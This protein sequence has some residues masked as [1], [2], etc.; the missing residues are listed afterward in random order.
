MQRNWIGKSVGGEITFDLADGQGSFNVFTTRA[1][2]LFG[3]TYVVLAPEHPLVKQIT[4][5]SQLSAVE[6]YCDEVA[7]TDEIERLSTAKDKTGQYLRA[8]T[9]LTP[10]TDSACRCG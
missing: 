7:K 3:C 2:T 1:D 9:Q 5:K 4:T 6:K 8:R 10:L